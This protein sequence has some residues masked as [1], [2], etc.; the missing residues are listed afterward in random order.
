LDKL[1]TG[2]F[3]AVYRCR[4]EQLERDVAVKLFFKDPELCDRLEHVLHEAKSAARLRIPGVV[5]VLDTGQTEDGRGFVVYEFVHGP[6]LQDRIVAEKIG[7]EEAVRWVIQIAE[8]LHAV[9]KC[10]IVHRDVKPANILI[11]EAGQARLTDFGIAKLDDHFFTDDAGAQVGTLAYMSPEQAGGM[12]HWAT[13]Q[14]DI[15]SLGAVLYHEL[16]GRPP[17]IG[18]DHVDLC[19]QILDRAVRPPRTI[20]DRISRKLEAVCLKALA[21]RPDD[22][23]RTAADMAAALRAAL[24]PRRRGVRYLAVA[25]MAASVLIIV[26]ALGWSGL[27]EALGGSNPPLPPPKVTP[28]A[29]SPEL[30]IQVDHR[31][32]TWSITH[33]SC[34]QN[35]AWQNGDLVH[36]NA[37]NIE[38]KYVCIY[39]YDSDG[40]PHR[41]LPEKDGNLH[42]RITERPLDLP[43]VDA[44]YEI[45]GNPGTECI[46][47]CVARKTPDD[48]QDQQLGA[49]KKTKLVLSPA[50]KEVGRPTFIQSRLADESGKPTE[51]GPGPAR[52]LRDPLAATEVGKI[53]KKLSM[54]YY[55]FLLPHK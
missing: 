47:L 13:P 5:A 35:E 1:G 42:Q 23:F 43:A 41:M 18:A 26:I 55:G 16:C 6:T 8:A 36:L 10:S 30:T 11:D 50:L 53:L 33:S 25:G 9:H 54:D 3:G 37:T 17:F 29:K 49:L 28:P 27:I 51:R 22:R 12:S 32:Q 19:E 14:S 52:S 21:K 38:G 2:K 20:D 15:Y 46:L 45:T 34:G 31:G 4:D 40:A 24:A 44:G 48:K 39:W 7:H